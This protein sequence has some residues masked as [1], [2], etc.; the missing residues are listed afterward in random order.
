MDISLL[1]RR[2]KTV[3]QLIFVVLL[4]VSCNPDLDYTVRGYTQKMMVEGSIETGKHPSVYLSLNVPLWKTLDSATVLDHVIRYA[5]VTITD[6][7]HTEILMSKWDKTRFPP[8]V[9]TGTELVGEEGKNYSLKVEYSGYTLHATTSLPVSTR[10]DSIR[11]KP[12]AKSDSLVAVSVW[13]NLGENKQAGLRLFSKKMQDNRF[14]E[15]PIIYNNTF[16]LS[17]Q[18]ELKLSPKPLRSDSSYAEG[19]YFRLGDTIDIKICALDAQSTRFFEGL[20]AF[21]TITDNIGTT[22]IKPLS[23]NISEPGFGIWYGSGTRQYR[24]VVRK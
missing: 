2:F 23:S 4:F 24:F 5:K 17:G 9:Y 20:S 16:S 1:K 19:A 13:V 15:T 8:Y 10:I 22:E 3:V 18:Q 6:G 12:S 14:I 21:S 11:F 7:E